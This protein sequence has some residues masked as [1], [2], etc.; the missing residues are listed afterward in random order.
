MK[1]NLGVLMKMVIHFFMLV[2]FADSTPTFAQVTRDVHLHT[3]VLVVDLGFEHQ[4]KLCTQTEP[5]NAA[6]IVCGRGRI[7]HVG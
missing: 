7:L 1:F 4:Q 2:L 5:I 3:L 6:C